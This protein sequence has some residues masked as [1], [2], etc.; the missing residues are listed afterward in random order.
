MKKRTV[1]P[2][3]VRNY[4]ERYEHNIDPV[5]VKLILSEVKPIQCQMVMNRMADEG[6]RTSTIYQAR[7]TLFNMLDYA[8]QN[9]VIMKNPCNG[10]VK[11]DIGK[12]T[13]KKEALTLEW[14]KRFV[15]GIV[16]NTYEYQYKFLLQT[17]LRTGELVGLKSIDR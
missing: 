15:K 16:G 17:G 7:I 1:R 5:I 6:Y 13:Q 2:N 3:T 4:T 11:S 9:D 8:Y 12:P 14:Q 10:M